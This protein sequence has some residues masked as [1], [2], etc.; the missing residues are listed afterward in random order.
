MSAEAKDQQLYSELLTLSLSPAT[1]QRK[2]SHYPKLMTMGEGVNMDGLEN[3]DLC[4][5]AQL[6]LPHNSPVQ[7]HEQD[8]KTL[9]LLHL[10]QQQK[11]KYKTYVLY[12]ATPLFLQCWWS[13]CTLTLDWTDNVNAFM[14]SKYKHWFGKYIQCDQ[15]LSL[16]AP[17]ASLLVESKN[18]RSDDS[19]FS[20]F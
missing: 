14:D 12:I 2:L 4:L 18:C 5:P 9:E 20:T 17:K 7:R 10:G 8:P 1:Q 6:P 16:R 3:R 15:H 11:Y 13:L 19:L